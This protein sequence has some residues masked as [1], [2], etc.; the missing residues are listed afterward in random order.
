M[1]GKELT[2]AVS[3]LS[4][5]YLELKNHHEQLL[6][7]VA[8]LASFVRLAVV[9][10]PELGKQ[11]RTT[12]IQGISLLWRIPDAARESAVQWHQLLSAELQSPPPSTGG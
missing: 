10:Y 12:D 1:N 3:N 11:W 8:A 6:G 4:A 9:Q 7:Q 2:E 5:C